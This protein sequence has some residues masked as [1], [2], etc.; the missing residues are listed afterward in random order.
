MAEGAALQTGTKVEFVTK[1][2]YDN[3]FNV[4]S[5]NTILLEYASKIGAPDISELR[6]K[7]GST[8]FSSVTY[9]V[10]GACIRVKYVDRGVSSHSQGWLDLGKT[11]RAK[12]TILNGAKIIALTVNYIVNNPEQLTRIKDEFSNERRI[13]T[14]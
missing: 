1:K 7:T 3:K 9:R 5:L 13:A 14:L 6:K 4:P 12:D 10:P 11:E 2:A 8:D